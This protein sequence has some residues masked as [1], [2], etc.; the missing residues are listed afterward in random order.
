VTP[1]STTARQRWRSTR[2]GGIA[3][4]TD[5]IKMATAPS[6]HFAVL[7]RRR[8]ARIKTVSAINPSTTNS[9]VRGWHTGRAG[10]RLG[11]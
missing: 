4:F 11:D 9:M 10:N 1:R 2:H 7:R 6:S 3:V 8:D 5:A